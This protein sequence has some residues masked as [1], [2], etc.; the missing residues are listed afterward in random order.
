MFSEFTRD[1]LRKLA[2]RQ[3]EP[4]VSI[5][6]PLHMEM[7]EALRNP[8]PFKKLLSDAERQLS[9]DGR[10]ASMITRMVQPRRDLLADYGFWQQRSMGLA[11]FLSPYGFYPFRLPLPFPERLVIANHFYTRPLL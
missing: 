6:T 7:P 8:V 5:Y 11:A 1:D 9:A 10:P 2:A 4:C 3:E